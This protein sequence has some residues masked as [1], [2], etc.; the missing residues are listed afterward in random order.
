M[1]EKYILKDNISDLF[2]PKYDNP[3]SYPDQLA[4]EYYKAQE[5]LESLETY[6]N[7]EKFNTKAKLDMLNKI[8]KVYGKCNRGIENYCRIQSLEA[9]ENSTDNNPSSDTQQNSSDNNQNNNKPV[10]K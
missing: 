8:N 10:D 3:E 5:Y 2:Q 6:Y 9:E 1:V 4:T 7:I